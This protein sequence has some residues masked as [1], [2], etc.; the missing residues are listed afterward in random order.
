[1]TSAFLLQSFIPL[2]SLTLQ[3]SER[4]ARGADMCRD[5]SGVA[6]IRGHCQEHHY[7]GY[8]QEASPDKIPSA[9]LTAHYEVPRSFRTQGSARKNISQVNSPEPEQPCIFHFLHPASWRRRGSE[10]TGTLFGPLTL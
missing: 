3:H 1:M 2:V 9:S 6:F 10:S 4:A 7:L 5:S 8:S